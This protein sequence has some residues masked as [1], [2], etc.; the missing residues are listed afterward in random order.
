[1]VA[2]LEAYQG[3]SPGDTP[4]YFLSLTTDPG[5][6]FDF[7]DTNIISIPDDDVLYGSPGVG[8]KIS[9]GTVIKF[10]L[11][12]STS[13]WDWKPVPLGLS[14]T[15]NTSAQFSFYPVSYDDSCT[16]YDVVTNIYQGARNTE[17]VLW[18]G[19]KTDIQLVYDAKSPERGSVCY[20]NSEQRGHNVTSTQEA[21]RSRSLSPR[22]ALIVDMPGW[23][24]NTGANV[25]ATDFVGIRAG[26]ILQGQNAI[27]RCRPG[28]CGT[29]EVVY[30]TGRP[31]CCGCV[32]MDIEYQFSKY[33]TITRRRNGIEAADE[34]EEGEDDRGEEELHVLAPRVSG[35]ATM[36]TKKVTACRRSFGLGGDWRYPSFPSRHDFDWEGIENGAWDTI[37]R[38]W[39][40]TTDSCAS[41]AVGEL[42]R[43]DTRWTTDANGNPTR[44]RANYQTKHVFAGQ[45]IGDFF[46]WWLAQGRIKNQLP[47]HASPRSKLSCADS[48]LYLLA[49]NTNLPWRLP[50]AT[51]DT[52]VINL[53]LS[54]PGS[55]ND[56]DRLTIMLARPNGKMSR[57]FT[58]NEPTDRNRYKCMNKDSQLQSVKEMGLI[59]QYFNTQQVWDK[60]YTTYE[61][62]YEHFGA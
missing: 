32:N 27:F 17:N 23:G 24:Y 52:P 62:I 16:D 29:C 38:Y 56:L 3:I 18:G 46:D 57:M 49:A 21:S 22:Q 35:M 11:D 59:V 12:V 28:A 54:E 13:F 58:G 5:N 34:E 51:K 48:L 1:M 33:P 8:G 2:A 26:K 10:G 50:G 42:T 30:D 20:P 60:L 19:D 41:W 53:L 37:S 4:V 43:H 55:K 47:A 15:Y 31:G 61:A 14:L 39:G 9:L 40:N 45:L 6:N 25:D 36:G 7:R 44:I